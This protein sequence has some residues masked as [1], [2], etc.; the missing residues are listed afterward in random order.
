MVSTLS[1]SKRSRTIVNAVVLP[2]PAFAVEDIP[3]SPKFLR[4]LVWTRLLTGVLNSLHS[5]G[6]LTV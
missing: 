3:R 6:L 2:I 5:I 4:P 1:S